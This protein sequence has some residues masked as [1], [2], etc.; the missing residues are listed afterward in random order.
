MLSKLSRSFTSTLPAR[1]Y[2]RFSS[3]ITYRSET[4]SIGAIDV[5]S[6]KYWG[7]QTQRSLENFPIG[8]PREQMPLPVIKAMGIVKKCA[9][10]YNLKLGKL[11]ANIAQNI[12]KAADDVISGKLDDHFPLVSLLYFLQQERA[13]YKITR[14]GA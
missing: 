1:K 6:S 8:G 14:V 5:D 10:K 2:V 13:K 3:G 7:A 9:A 4:D 12:I 11:E